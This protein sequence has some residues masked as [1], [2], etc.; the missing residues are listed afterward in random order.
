MPEPGAFAAKEGVRRLDE[1]AGA[2]AGVLL[3]AA[4]AA[5]FQVVQDL[6]TVADD[7]VRL[8][9][10]QI[11]DEADAAGVVLVA[12]VVQALLGGE[13]VR[14]HVTSSFSGRSDR[15][16]CRYSGADHGGCH[17]AAAVR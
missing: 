9:I 10:F 7:V 16:P 13:G 12:R 8:P 4:G 1:D 15:G 5:V 2:V 14:G 3:A 11:D 6:Q 17:F